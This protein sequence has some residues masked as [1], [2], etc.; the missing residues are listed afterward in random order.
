ML[1]A[2]AAWP[3]VARVS[4][5][6]RWLFFRL[7][8]VVTLVLWIP[9]LY[10]LAR[11]QPPRAVA[12]LMVMHLAIAV[13]TYNLLVRLAPADESAPVA[14][15]LPSTAAADR[16]DPTPGR[17]GP[18]DTVDEAERRTD[19]LAT[20]LALL[21]GIELV[22]G[23][24]VVVSVPTGRP[25]G[26]LPTRGKTVYLA[27]AVLG[28]LLAL[29]AV[30]YLVRSRDSTR[31]VR[32]S[33]WI[34]SAGVAAAGVGGLLAAAHPWRLV[35]FA[36]M[37]LGSVVAGFGYLLPTLDRMTEDPPHPAGEPG[38]SAGDR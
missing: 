19:R 15:A 10:L 32:L 2:C 24:A 5:D 22:V 12:A 20:W 37:L 26:W 31:M 25:T 11:H 33:G 9:D 21:V 7:A 6:P 30:L 17:A 27:H 4:W 14:Q 8:V 38:P 1:I 3:I 13:L 34:G 23:I 16:T 28:L 35:G 29:G 36:L 18:A